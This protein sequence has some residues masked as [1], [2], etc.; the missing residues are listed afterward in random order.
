MAIPFRRFFPPGG[1]KV[2]ALTPEKLRIAQPLPLAGLSPRE[3]QK[4]QTRF[5]QVSQ[6]RRHQYP[7]AHASVQ[8]CS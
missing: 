1:C 2:R 4:R 6:N 3:L 5:L 7:Q 8:W